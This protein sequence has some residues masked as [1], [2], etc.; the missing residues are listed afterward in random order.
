MID[1]PE[2]ATTT[3]AEVTVVPDDTEAPDADSDATETSA[4]DTIRNTSWSNDL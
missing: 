3:V 1:D 4:R 2:A